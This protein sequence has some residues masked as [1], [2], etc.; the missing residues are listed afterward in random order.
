MRNVGYRFVTP[1]KGE[2]AAEGARAKA[3]RQQAGPDRQ[4]TA[5]ADETATL[6][7]TEAPSQA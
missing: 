5:D 3:D 6:D 7:T 2:R 4:K 1:D